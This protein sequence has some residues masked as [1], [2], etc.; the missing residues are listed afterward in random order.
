M[1]SLDFVGEITYTISMEEKERGI[2]MQN[3]AVRCGTCNATNT[4]V[5]KWV[6]DLGDEYEVNVCESCNNAEH[7]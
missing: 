2:P 7:F 6:D 4:H 1:K 5:E 3:V